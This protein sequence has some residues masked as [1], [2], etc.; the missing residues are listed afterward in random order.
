[1]T[2]PE[3]VDIDKI[4]LVNQLRKDSD[5]CITELI[6]SIRKVGLLHPVVVRVN[7]NEHFQVVCGCRR[8][9][10]CKALK[11]KKIPCVVID[12]NDREAFEISLVENIHRSSLEPI[13]E[14]NAFKRYVLD[15]GWGGI[16]ELA[17]ILGRSHSY[18]IKRITLLDL[19]Q[20][21]IDFINNRQLTP[22]AAEELFPIRD[23]S[24]QS[25]LAKLIVDRQLSSKEAREVVR[26]TK[27]QSGNYYSS[28]IPDSNY[29]YGYHTQ[30]HDGY[31]D[32]V[33]AIDRS[34]RKSILTLRIAMSRIVAIIDEYEDNWFVYECLMEEKNALHRQIDIL[35]KKKK[36]LIK[37]MDKQSY[38]K[39]LCS[40]I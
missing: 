37:M 15:L 21:I 6:D 29:D 13:E 40:V 7:G 18:I 22:S 35:F 34:L 33:R 9:T 3:D 27:N 1:L 2:I 31:H 5:Y 26:S 10:A 4:S 24:K 14:A 38:S 32:E 28:Q 23:E 11:W 36:K 30:H 39:K 19:P 20:D 17:S 25:E 16:S 8:Y 12:A